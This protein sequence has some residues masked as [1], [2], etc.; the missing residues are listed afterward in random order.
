MFRI[1]SYVIINCVQTNYFKRMSIT[2]ILLE[3]QLS[4]SDDMET[5]SVDSSGLE[6]LRRRK[7][8]KVTTDM[9]TFETMQEVRDNLDSIIQM[10]YEMFL[11]SDGVEEYKEEALALMRDEILFDVEQAITDYFTFAINN[12]MDDEDFHSLMKDFSRSDETIE[13]FEDDDLIKQFVE[14][15]YNNEIGDSEDKV[16][17]INKIIT[18]TEKHIDIFFKD[19]ADEDFVETNY[20][21][22]FVETMKNSVVEESNIYIAIDTMEDESLVIDGQE[23]VYVE[24]NINIE[25]LDSIKENLGI[26][27]SWAVDGGQ[28]YHGSG[29]THEVRLIGYAPVS[30]INWEETSFKSMWSLKHEQEV[31]LLEDVP[32]YLQKIDILTATDIRLNAYLAELASI[33]QSTYFKGKK[34]GKPEYKK[35]I[36]DQLIANRQKNM[37]DVTFTEFLLTST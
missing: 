32:V 22:S 33:I 12:D 20:Y 7:D 18:Y 8:T 6:R 13:N 9:Q 24:R 5:L 29:G 31:E 19:Y 21:D 35:A 16:T 15:M 23:C 17:T 10:G 26:Y 30:S 36:Y 28:V 27:W 11:E 1:K 14:D 2:N 25:N 3:N 37:S 34:F 4:L